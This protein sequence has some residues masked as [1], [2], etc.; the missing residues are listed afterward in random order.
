MSVKIFTPKLR[1]SMVKSYNALQ[2]SFNV[3]SGNFVVS[4]YFALKKVG[5]QVKAQKFVANKKGT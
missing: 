3:N 4:R 5:K 2:T 1:V